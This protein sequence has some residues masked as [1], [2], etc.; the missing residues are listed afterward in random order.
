MDPLTIIATVV[1][2]AQGLGTIAQFI[3]DHLEKRDQRKE[4]NGLHPSQA[5]LQLSQDVND[6]SSR[7]GRTLPDQIDQ[8]LLSDL[9]GLQ[10]KVQNML[11]TLNDVKRVSSAD[12]VD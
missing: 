12:N 6:L 11:R 7:L 1:A 3:D 9:K 10:V 2:V 4:A 8:Q 5:A